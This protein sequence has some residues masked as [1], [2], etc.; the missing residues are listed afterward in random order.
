MGG[1]SDPA[2]ARRPTA[3]PEHPD[4]PPGASRALAPDLARGATL[5]DAMGQACAMAALSVQHPG[6]QT[7]FPGPEALPAS[8]R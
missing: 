5:R 3:A 6:T 2:S 1:V 8:W 7:S 4:P